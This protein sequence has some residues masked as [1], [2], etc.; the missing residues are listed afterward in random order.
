MRPLLA[1]AVLLSCAAACTPPQE[2]AALSLINLFEAATVEDAFTPEPRPPALEWSFNGEST[3]QA[4]EELAATAGW[5]SLNGI[6]GLEVRDG[7]L[8]GR[9]TDIPLLVSAAPEDL[10]A[11]DRLHA[12]EIRM[13]VSA[14]TRLGVSFDADEYS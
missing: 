9:T 13:R 10:D 4:P 8:A 12:I 2:P 7:A 6:D 5:K 3:V 1:A 11:G 14:G